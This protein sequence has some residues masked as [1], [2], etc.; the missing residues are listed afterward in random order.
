[1][2]IIITRSVTT[3]ETPSCSQ[4]ARGA[5]IIQYVYKR[6]DLRSVKSECINREVSVEQVIRPYDY[7]PTVRELIPRAVTGELA[8]ISTKLIPNAVRLELA[9]VRSKFIAY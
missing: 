3:R 4:I 1:M 2:V 9:A 6:G 5:V 7:W 8:A